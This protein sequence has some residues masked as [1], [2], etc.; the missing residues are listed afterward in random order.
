MFLEYGTVIWTN[1]AVNQRGI[2]KK[3]LSSV[4]CDTRAR[5]RAIDEFAFW[6]QPEFP[7]ESVVCN[8]TVTLFTSLKTNR[9][10]LNQP[11]QMLG[12][13]LEIIFHAFAMTDVFGEDSDAM[14]RRIDTDF[15][16]VPLPME[17]VLAD[18]SFRLSRS[19]C[20]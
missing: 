19:Q 6:A 14:A 3:L 13:P 12:V 8:Y 10:F 7:V 5:R 2:G 20:L 1:D 4:T 15:E 11:L 18:E 16:S 9:P 17:L